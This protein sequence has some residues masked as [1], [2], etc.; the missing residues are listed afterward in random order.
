MFGVN[1]PLGAPNKVLVCLYKVYIPFVRRYNKCKRKTRVTFTFHL[2][3]EW[4]QS[5]LISLMYYH[6]DHDGRDEEQMQGT[7]SSDGI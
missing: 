7:F 6:A 3:F 4:G 5:P 1:V 2:I